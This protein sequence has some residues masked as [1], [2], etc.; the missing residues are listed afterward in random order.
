MNPYL[1]A[2]I[3]IVSVA[4]AV[5]VMLAVRRRAPEGGFFSDSDRASG[6]FGFL[7]AGFVILLG[8]VIF[9]SFGT[10]DNARVQSE[11][12]ATAVADQFAEAEVMPTGV[13]DRAQGQLICYARSVIRSEWP[14]MASGMTSPFTDQWVVALEQTGVDLPD[15]TSRQD[16]ALKAWYAAANE[17]ELGRRARLL[18]SQGEIP[19]LL[20]ALIG[21]AAL[22][23]V[24]YVFLYAD[25][26]ERW[27]PQVVMAGGVTALV[28]A[29][30]LAVKVLSSPFK[31]E[32]GSI[33][34]VGME[35]T[36]GILKAELAKEGRAL[37]VPCTPTGAPR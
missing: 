28:V 6:V 23:V 3:I 7:G 18:V 31:N 5:A 16:A 34:P 35:Y 33:T 25:P 1:A 11:A 21:I 13:R 9:L 19:L 29:S 36:L 8:F 14:A 15:R 4:L 2:A 10:Y 20:W 24:G 30:L 12:E 22:L 17:R 26:V 37:P 32:S 27:L